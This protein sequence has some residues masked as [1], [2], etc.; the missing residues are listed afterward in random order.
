MRSLTTLHPLA[1][2]WRY[3][4]KGF[5]ALGVIYFLLWVRPIQRRRE[6]FAANPYQHPSNPFF[7]FH[8]GSNNGHF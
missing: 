1:W 5:L 7:V 6:R 3:L 4:P 8:S 2:I